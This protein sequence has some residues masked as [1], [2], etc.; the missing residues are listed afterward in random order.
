MIKVIEIQNTKNPK[1]LR[2]LF[3]NADSFAISLGS[4][5]GMTASKAVFTD[6]NKLEEGQ[7]IP[8]YEIRKQVSDSPMYEGHKPF[9]VDGKYYS[10]IIVN[11]TT[12]EQL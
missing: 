6:K 1:V 12:G 10:A 3:A 8:G 2:V 4:V 9:E 11:S 7:I 5:T